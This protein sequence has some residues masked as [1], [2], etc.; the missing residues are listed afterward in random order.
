MKVL[1][2][3]DNRFPPDI[4]VES[5]MAS[6]LGAG[7]DVHLL[8]RDDARDAIDLPKSLSDLVV[9]TVTPKKDMTWWRRQVPNLPL[10]WFEDARWGR[11]IRMLGRRVGPFD[12]IH[13]HDLPLVKTGLR[14]GRRMGAKVVADLHENYPIALP[15][16]TRGMTLS[17]LSRFLLDP[18][19]WE[20]YERRS[21]PACSAVI[22]VAD[23][24]KA[25]L[26]SVGVPPAQI[27]VVENFVDVERYLSYPV[28]PRLPEV[29]SDPFVITYVGGLGGSHDLET[30]IRAMPSVVRAIPGAVMVI[31]G[32]GHRRPALELIVAEL[33]IAGHVRF[34]GWAEFASVPSYLAAADVCVLPLLQSVQTDAG[35]ANKL[36]QYM[37]AGKPVAATAC[38]G[39]RRVVEDADCG[40]LFPPTDS[41]AMAEAL[42]RLTSVELRTRLGENGRRAVHDRYNWSRAAARLLA[43]YEELARPVPVIPSRLIDISG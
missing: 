40:L 9:H 29:F 25:R 12:V 22:A 32:D 11:E 14:A 26:V 21:V 34:E 41:E 7:H 1:M 16:Y 36:F 23:E 37:L 28:D 5:E 8:C 17:P 19:R 35:L 24:M 4:R 30:A 33:G 10:L 2:L 38:T 20:D 31:V 27:T 43:M 39:T 6:L 18:R 42:I 15:F 3:L 13:V